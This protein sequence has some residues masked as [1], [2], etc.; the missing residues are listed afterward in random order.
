MEQLGNFALKELHPLDLRAAETIILKHRSQL[1]ET[2]HRIQR[3]RDALRALE[4]FL[5]SLKTAALPGGL[6]TDPSASGTKV[7]PEDTLTVKN[8]E[9]DIYLMKEKARHLD[10]RLKMLNISFKDAGQGED[11]SCEKLLNA[12]AKP[13][14]ETRGSGRQE[15]LMEEE[16]LLDTCIFKNNEL[17]KSILEVQ[18]QI[19]KIG[20][21]DPTVPAIKQR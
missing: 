19:S 11:M 17:L 3:S 5:A 7:A 16:K 20:L 8:K 15:E 9:G 21:K 1:E 4:D 14:L 2:N 12:L 10:E 18:S 13:S 6:V